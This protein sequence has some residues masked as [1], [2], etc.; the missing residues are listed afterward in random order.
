MKIIVLTLIV[1]LFLGI[2]QFIKMLRSVKL[3]EE[4]YKYMMNKEIIQNKECYGMY[5]IQKAQQE[6][7]LYLERKK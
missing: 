4:D 1:F 5:E 7:D 3:T 2:Y 6:I